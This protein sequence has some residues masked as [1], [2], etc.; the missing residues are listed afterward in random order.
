M[1]NDDHNP[2][3]FHAEY[4]GKTATYIIKEPKLMNGSLG[5][6][7]DKLVL[8]WAEIHQEELLENWELAINNQTIKK[9]KPLE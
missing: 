8:E 6:R 4:S 1:Y 5:I 2:P 3:H 7:A 9:I